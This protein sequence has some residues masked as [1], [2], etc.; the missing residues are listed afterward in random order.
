[1]SAGARNCP[2]LMLM[3]RPVLRGRDDQVGLP[4]QER[5]NLQHV[6]DLGD[7]RG[8]I[9]LVNVGQDRHAQRAS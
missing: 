1:M 3:V 4:R 6:G 9:G 7:R 2:F 5:G 8:L